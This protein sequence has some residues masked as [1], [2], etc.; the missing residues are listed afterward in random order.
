M[1]ALKIHIYEKR[2]S[3]DSGLICYKSKKK[4]YVPAIHLSRQN[5]FGLFKS[6]RCFSSH[7]FCSC[8]IIFRLLMAN[9]YYSQLKWANSCQILRP[10]RLRKERYK[11]VKLTPVSKHYKI[12]ATETLLYKNLDGYKDI[13]IVFCLCQAVNLFHL[14]CLSI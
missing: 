14:F 5:Q 11:S 3:T 1:P 10:A 9:C 4:H 2:W 13:G 6:Q 8:E 12:T 7:K